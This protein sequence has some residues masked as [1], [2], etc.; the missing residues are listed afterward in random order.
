MIN[1]SLIEVDGVFET[2]GHNICYSHIL[3]RSGLD[4]RLSVMICTMLFL[5]EPFRDA[6]Y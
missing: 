6:T 4:C 2:D 3:L 1:E 5:V